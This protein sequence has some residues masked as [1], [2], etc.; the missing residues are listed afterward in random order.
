MPSSFPLFLSDRLLFPPNHKQT[1][2]IYCLP[3]T[4]TYDH[5]Y[6]VVRNTYALRYGGTESIARG[7]THGFPSRVDRSLEVG[8][9]AV[10]VVGLS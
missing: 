5:P 8:M 10:N 9:Y 1:F 6:L 3:W 7:N 4:V 2:E